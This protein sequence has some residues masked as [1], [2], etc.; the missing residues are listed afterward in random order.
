MVV[1][2]LMLTLTCSGYWSS[3]VTPPLCTILSYSMVVLYSRDHEGLGFTGQ[4]MSFFYC[5]LPSKLFTILED[6]AFA[7]ENQGLSAAL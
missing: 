6:Y 5:C 1:L 2:Y 3:L 7:R 4:K